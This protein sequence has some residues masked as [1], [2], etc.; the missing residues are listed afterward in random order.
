MIDKIKSKL[1][2]IPGFIHYNFQKYKYELDLF[3]IRK[4]QARQ[5]KKLKGKQTVKVA[6]F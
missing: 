3:V 6:F 4:K 5:L 2:N 1:Q